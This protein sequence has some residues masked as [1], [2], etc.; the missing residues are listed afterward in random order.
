MKTVTRKHLTFN[1]L[2]GLC[3]NTQN[4][5]LNMGYLKENI[6]NVVDIEMRQDKS[7]LT[8]LK[9]KRIKSHSILWNAFTVLVNNHLSY[10]YNDG[11]V[12]YVCTSQHLKD[13][14]KSYGY[15]YKNCF[16]DLIE[17]IEQYRIELLNQ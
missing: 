5:T 12:A 17:D 16:I 14:L 2:D 3:L 7:Y 11:N 6:Y 4:N 15:D 13:Y 10:E 1:V 9:N 8:H